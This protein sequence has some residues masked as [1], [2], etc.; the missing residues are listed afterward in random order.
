MLRWDAIEEKELYDETIKLYRDPF[1]AA[2]TSKSPLKDLELD[3]YAYKHL[4]SEL[5]MYKILDVNF[6]EYIEKKFLEN[7]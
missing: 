5:F 6:I 3:H 4:G 7:D 1:V 2:S